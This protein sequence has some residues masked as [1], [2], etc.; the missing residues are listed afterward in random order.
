MKKLI[1]LSILSVSAKGFTAEN[2][3]RL[4]GYYENDGK[5]Y[6]VCISL[7]ETV[8]FSRGVKALNGYMTFATEYFGEV[9]MSPPGFSLSGNQVEPSGSFVFAV[10]D[11]NNSSESNPDLMSKVTSMEL[12]GDNLQNLSLIHENRTLVFKLR[13]L[14][15]KEDCSLSRPK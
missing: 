14:E 1:L 6:A 9:P 11:Q 15:E 8:W 3:H 4:G 2:I 13:N 5:K 7:F 12:K 10:S